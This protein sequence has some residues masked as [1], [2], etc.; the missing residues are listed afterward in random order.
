VVSLV[1][2]RSAGVRWAGYPGQPRSADRSGSAA[3]S[4][5]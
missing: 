1:L 3:V 5:P 4:L 2:A